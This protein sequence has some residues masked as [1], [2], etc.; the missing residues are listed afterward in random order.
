MVKKLGLVRSRGFLALWSSKEAILA[1]QSTAEPEEITLKTLLG[2][3]PDGNPYVEL[4]EFVLCENLVFET[5]KKA[6]TQWK[7]VWIPMVPLDE[8]DPTVQ[9]PPKPNRVKALLYS[10]EIRGGVDLDKLRHMPKVEGMVISRISTLSPQIRDLLQR[11]YPG[12]NFDTCL[13]V[14]QGRRPYSR[15]AVFLLW[16]GTLASL[17]LCAGG[18]LYRRKRRNKPER[19]WEPKSFGG[20]QAAQDR[21]E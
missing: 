18:W 1:F 12:S 16:G 4:T 2:R 9:D 17:A 10:T 21:R 11:S 15:L 14:H 20:R 19:E 13:I 8:V 3:G 7:S 6:P 5:P